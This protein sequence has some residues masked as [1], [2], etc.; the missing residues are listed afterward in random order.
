[1]QPLRRATRGCLQAKYALY[2]TDL[3]Y[4]D[5]RHGTKRA[6]DISAGFTRSLRLVRDK[7]QKPHSNAVFVLGNAPWH[8]VIEFITGENED[9]VGATVCHWGRAIICSMLSIACSHGS[10]LWYAIVCA[11]DQ[12]YSVLSGMQLLHLG[13]R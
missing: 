7:R 11:T 6:V 13:A 10:R 4:Y 3:V 1:M 2:T 12:I 5:H 9:V 8:T